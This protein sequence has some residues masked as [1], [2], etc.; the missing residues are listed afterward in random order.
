[1]GN[2]HSSTLHTGIVRPSMSAARSMRRSVYCMDRKA[3]LMPTCL[4]LYKDTGQVEVSRFNLLHEDNFVQHLRKGHVN[5]LLAHI[6]GK[7]PLTK[8]LH[9]A[10]G[11]LRG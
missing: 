8:P 5:A 10:E 1:M 7:A 3:P 6:I 9:F 11:C 4:Q 2:A